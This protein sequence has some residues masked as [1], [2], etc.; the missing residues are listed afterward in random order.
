MIDWG[1]QTTAEQIEAEKARHEA[2]AY[3]A[4][5]DWMVTRKAE[6]GKAIPQEVRDKRA[7]A[8]KAAGA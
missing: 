4:A 7:A 6:T 5:T 8:R 3:L 2:R 1:R